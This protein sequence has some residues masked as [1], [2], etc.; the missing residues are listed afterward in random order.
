MTGAID[1]ASEIV[2]TMPNA[3]MLQQFDNPGKRRVGYMRQI[4]GVAN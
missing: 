2:R 1:K 4:A 3:Y